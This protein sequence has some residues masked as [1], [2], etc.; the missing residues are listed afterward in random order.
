[1]TYGDSHSR[2]EKRKR[3]SDAGSELIGLGA[4]VA[5]LNGDSEEKAAT[6]NVDQVALDGTVAQEPSQ[7]N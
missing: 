2:G 4:T 3:D 6:P 5:R 7:E 1:M